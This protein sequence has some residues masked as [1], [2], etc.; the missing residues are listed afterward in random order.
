[1]HLRLSAVP[2]PKVPKP[3]KLKTKEGSGT[4]LVTIL[5]VLI[6]NALLGAELLNT[7]REILAVSLVIPRK[8]AELSKA[9][10]EVPNSSYVPNKLFA[11]R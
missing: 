11:S 2:T 3:S 10:E 5:R 1:M 6:P 7:N 9:S 4:R 8:R